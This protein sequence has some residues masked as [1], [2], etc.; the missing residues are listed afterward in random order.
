MTLSSRKMLTLQS[1]SL[2]TKEQI[3]LKR[4][5]SNIVYRLVES[6]ITTSS[7]FDP[8]VSK[9]M[10]IESVRY[11]RHR[12]ESLLQTTSYFWASKGGR[13]SLLEKIIA[14]IGYP[15]AT[16]G[17]TLSNII[18]K[19]VARSNTDRVVNQKNV[20]WLEK[21]NIKKLKFDLVNII[22]DRLII[23]EL[24]NRVDSGG[25]AAR[26]EA[27]SKKFFAL[28]RL[29]EDGETILHY[30]DKDYDFPSM[31]SKMGINR[32]EMILGLLFNINGK[33]ATISDDR[34]YGFFSASRNLMKNYLDASHYSVTNLRFDKNKLSMSY[35]KQELEVSFEMLYGS[36]VIRKF[37]SKSYGITELM[38]RVFPIVWDDIWLVLNIAIQ[39]R[40]I[41]LGH[42]KN[43]II[44]LM[45]LYDEDEH[46]T[47]FC[48]NSL[49]QEIL[50]NL[51]NYIAVKKEF[52]DINLS[53]DLNQNNDGYL[54][55]CL[56]AFA[57]YILNKPNIGKSR[58]KKV[59]S[60]DLNKGVL[61][62]E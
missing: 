22:G 52:S 34:K 9:F 44:H 47:R 16:F 31:L 19:L 61:L 26:E 60:L 6:T 41:L 24:K 38:T 43:H 12:Y 45:K 3:L 39:Q 5:Y 59:E 56:F 46:F 30:M 23:L 21:N 51:I 53:P 48:H 32:V 29:I 33:E 50:V 55:D 54:A 36:E 20:L 1:D 14:S 8:F 57:S 18:S 11:D 25:T 4:T 37:T 62:E 2:L 42:G 7:E 49:N 15:I 17:V 27:L 40:T 35:N 13:G 10:G 28:S 58:K